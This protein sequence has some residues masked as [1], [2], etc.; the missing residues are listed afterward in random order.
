MGCFWCDAWVNAHSSCCCTTLT[1]H[2]GTRSASQIQWVFS[3]VVAVQEP[4]HSCC[5]MAFSPQR[6]VFKISKYHNIQKIKNIP[7]NI[8]KQNVTFVTITDYNDT[9]LSPKIHGL[10]W[11]DGSRWNISKIH[12]H[13]EQ[14]LLKTD[15]KLAERLLY[16]QGCKKDVHVTS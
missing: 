14:F 11:G 5:G 1:P 12:L 6:K 16:N 8:P 15:W 9:L 7:L 13:M 2:C 3:L 10:H 4:V